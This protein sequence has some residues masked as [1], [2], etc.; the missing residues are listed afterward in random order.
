MDVMAVYQRALMSLAFFLL[1]TTAALAYWVPMT[2]EEKV[3]AA[4][5]IAVVQVT[6]T[7]S[8]PDHPKIFLRDQASLRV[9]RLFKGRTKKPSVLVG[10]TPW[11]ACSSAHYRRGEEWLVFLHRVS[12]GVYNTVDFGAGQLKVTE[13]SLRLIEV[14]TSKDVKLREPIQVG[15]RPIKPASW[16]SLNVSGV[17]PGMTPADVAAAVGRPSRK[18]KAGTWRYR[19]K[20]IALVRFG[21]K[22]RVSLS[23]GAGL[24]IG[25]KRIVE[26]FEDPAF[27]KALGPP[28]QLVGDWHLF[29]LGRRTLAV[30]VKNDSLGRF[31]L[32]AGSEDFRALLKS[33]RLRLPACRR[34]AQAR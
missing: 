13:S 27:L 1:F 14:M 30:E 20:E 18:T 4:D 29:R 12:P 19:N 31:C 3:R 21:P 28:S 25:G 17:R 26:S 6:S 5:V 15:P 10:F 34:G 24:R 23:L 2:M 16:R 11:F 7:A 8:T 33:G 9:L 22:R 32:F